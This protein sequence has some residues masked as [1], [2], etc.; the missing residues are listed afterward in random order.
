MLK[1]LT[2]VKTDGLR[3]RIC[4]RT[5]TD[6]H[7]VARKVILHY[8][9]NTQ[10]IIITRLGVVVRILRSRTLGQ[11][12]TLIRI[13]NL[14]GIYSC[15]SC[16]WQVNLAGPIPFPVKVPLIPSEKSSDPTIDFSLDSPSIFSH[17]CI[18]CLH[19]DGG[20]SISL[21][22]M[23]IAPDPYKKVTRLLTGLVFNPTAYQANSLWNRLS[24]RM[25]FQRLEH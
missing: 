11:F 22:S 18:G 16:L 21:Q 13:E 4:I 15:V 24:K 8:Q 2:I 10:Q 3:V 20:Q 7:T 14:G 9:E 19:S 6:T 12:P 1:T 23:A 17:H 5:H 25:P